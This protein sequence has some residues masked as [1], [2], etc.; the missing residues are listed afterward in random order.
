MPEP[1]AFA[2]AAAGLAAALLAAAGPARAATDPLRDDQWA[3]ARI[4]APDAWAKSTGKGVTIAIVDSGV[5]L[6]HPDLAERIAS[7]YDCRN[8]CGAGGDDDHGHGSHVAGIAAAATDNGTGI[9]GVAPDAR[10]MPVK[11]LSSNGA[12]SC[13]DVADGTRWAADHGADVI[14]LSLGP[15]VAL[16]A[17]VLGLAGCLATLQDAVGHA[18]GRGAVIVAA[19]GNDDLPATFYTGTAHLFVVG[20]TGPDDTVAS[21]SNN[22]VGIDVF[23]P[24]GD[25]VGGCDVHDCILSTYKGGQ[26]ALAEGTSMATPHVAGVAALLVAQG[27]GNAEVLDR[28]TDTADTT[29]DGDDR[30]NARQAVGARRGIGGGGSGG[31]TTGGGAQSGESGANGGARRGGGAKLDLRPSPAGSDTPSADVEAGGDSE[32]AAPGSGAAGGAALAP[33]GGAAAAIAIPLV[34]RRLLRRRA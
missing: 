7:H 12:G 33:L 18:W 26:Y 27:L 6:D 32:A 30:V 14:N 25:S 8:G 10:I 4:E 5:D 2:R 20:A 11:V 24:G 21:Y 22:L 19:A 16:D 13:D 17:T 1:R 3:L 31:A 34:L 23:A 29:P 28:I 15:D 9:A